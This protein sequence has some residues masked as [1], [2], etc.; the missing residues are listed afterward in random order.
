MSIVMAKRIRAR[1]RTTTSFTRRFT[2]ARGRSSASSCTRRSP[3]SPASSRSSTA[4]SPSR[5]LR[6]STTS[7]GPAASWPA[8]PQPPR[9]P[10]MDDA[11]LRLKQ[12]L[13]RYTNAAA[14]T[15]QAEL[16]RN[17]A[18]NRLNDARKALEAAAEDLRVLALAEGQAERLFY[19]GD[20]VVVVT[21]QLVAVKPLDKEYSK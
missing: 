9:R 4:S 11:R 3:T 20:Q 17:E 18:V 5:R 10:P 16:K 7:S 15:L 14:E 1:T 2:T 8:W 21:A 12:A 6:T 19:L 13:E